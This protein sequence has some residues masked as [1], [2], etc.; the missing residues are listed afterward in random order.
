V[1]PGVYAM[2]GAAAV[3]GGV[4][5]VTIS[6]VVIMFELTGGLQLICPFM[7]VCML[8]KWVGDYYT[9]GIYDYLIIV[10][11]YPYL[12]EPD[13]VTY[14]SSA[15]DVMDES[16]D[17]LHPDGTTVSKLTEFLENAKYGGYPFTQSESDPTLLGYIHTQILLSFLKKKVRDDQ[18]V[19]ESTPVY[20]KKFMDASRDETKKGAIDISKFVDETI[21]VCVKKTPAVQLQ[22]MFRNLGV[23][24]V[25]VRDKANL[26]GLI[27][28]KSFIMHME[29]LHGHREPQS[30]EAGNA[31]AGLH[32]ALLDKK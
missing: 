18:F 27:T 21:V 24:L 8:A 14:H 32:E 20:F 1:Y 11:K 7:V 9:I 30:L 12:H 10:R 2:L 4:C 15:A 25:L 13:E 22:Q 29:E 6:L 26:I 16:I 28:K 23:K 3:L 5:R 31:K 17:C 19:K